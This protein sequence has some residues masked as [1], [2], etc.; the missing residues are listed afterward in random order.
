MG[1]DL[2]HLLDK[3]QSEGIDKAKAESDALLAD[4][5]AEARQIIATAKQEAD[6]AHAKAKQD[7]DAFQQRAAEVI[8]QA[9]RDAVLNVEQAV[10]RMMESL[11]LK[12][13]RAVMALPEILTQLTREAVKEYLAAGETHVSARLPK[14]AE[15][16]LPAL[17]EKLRQD[18][19][20]E[21]VEVVLDA[22]Q[23]SGFSVRTR[24]GR[25]EHDFS[26]EAVV[27][28]LSKSLRPQLAALL[29]EENK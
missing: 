10:Q 3:I 13:T 5:R 16:L 6:A 15:A 28:A 22:G 20:H 23:G 14:T 24:D 11:L 1:T 17:R 25:V 26:A 12:E 8:R 29:K 18:A 7:A 9:G 27:N 2:Q 19:A 21:K 4:A